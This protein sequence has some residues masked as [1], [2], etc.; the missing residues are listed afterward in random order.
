VILWYIFYRFGMFGPRKIWQPWLQLGTANTTR[1][2]QSATRVFSST[3]CLL[4]NNLLFALF[5][6]LFSAVVGKT[7]FRKL[8][9]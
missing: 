7:E 2:N 8:I 6:G 4:C 3:A 5:I 9:N 1:Y